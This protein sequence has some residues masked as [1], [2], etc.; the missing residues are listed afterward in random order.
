MKYTILILTILVII[1]FVYSTQYSI[2]IYSSKNN[3]IS[4]V[5]ENDIITFEKDG[6]DYI[7]IV[8][9]LT[10]DFTELTIQ[11]K[12]RSFPPVRV[13]LVP[14]D[15]KSINLDSNKTKDIDIS[16]ISTVNKRSSISISNIEPSSVKPP[17]EIPQNY[18]SE[19]P[20]QESTEAIQQFMQIVP[21][22]QSGLA[23]TSGQL[24]LFELVKGQ[25]ISIGSSKV[26]EK[27]PEAGTAIQIFQTLFSFKNALN[28]PSAENEVTGKLIYDSSAFL[29]AAW[30]GKD[31]YYN[32]RLDDI[33]SQ[34]LSFIFKNSEV[35]ANK[36][37]LSKEFKDQYVKIGFLPYSN[38]DLNSNLF[39]NLDGSVEIYND[40][41]KIKKAELTA[42]K[43]ISIKFS[44]MYDP[45][46]TAEISSLGILDYDKNILS[47]DNSK[48][49]FEN[50][51]SG[52]SIGQI[53]VRS[54]DSIISIET[55][56]PSIPYTQIKTDEEVI[57]ES[58][59]SKDALTPAINFISNP[60]T[61]Q[62]R[63]SSTLQI[64]PKSKFKTSITS[65][66]IQ[67]AFRSK[68]NS[69]LFSSPILVYSSQSNSIKL[70]NIDEIYN[71]FTQIKSLS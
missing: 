66:N 43:D 51:I 28:K 62:L 36:I 12:D 45:E 61:I 16:L 5:R 23:M 41:G 38:L 20:S 24:T 65:G 57:V 56:R 53:N 64:T 30:D 49:I 35:Y 15:I 11:P 3:L 44:P 14:N 40:N 2:N 29:L 21:Y 32:F 9:K 1:P 33:R 8:S 27:N 46:F 52:L 69:Y 71:E 47:F 34:D 59:L 7:A 60:S 70:S 54:E 26:A 17:Q 68:D 6:S 39:I 4:N 37:D 63:S 18:T 58:T 13:N 10:D 31:F 19:E 22:I 67:T 42:L 25:V 55:L 48:L 50:Q